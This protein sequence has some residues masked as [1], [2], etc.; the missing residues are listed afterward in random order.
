MA[1]PAAIGMAAAKALPKIA[2]FAKGVGAA[3]D[4]IGE[5]GKQ[6]GETKSVLLSMANAIGGKWIEMQDIAFQTGRSMAM[7]REMAMRYDR[8]LMHST[9]ELARQYGITAKEM[10]DFQKS[11]GEAIGRNVVLTKRQIESM[12]ALSKITDSATA[13]QLVD[14]FDKL[15]VG[16]EGSTA[17]IGL[18]QERAKALGVNASKAAKNL[19]SNIQLASRYSFKNGVADLEKMAIKSA[20]LR[21][22]M[23][24]VMSAADKFMDID[25]AIGTSARLQMLG[26]SF[27]AMFS[28]PMGAMYEAQA[29][30]K[31]FMD[32]LEKLVAGKGRYDSKTGQ[33]TFDPVTMMQM[34]EAA[35]QLGMSV[36]QLTNPAM[37]KVQN[38]KVD[39]ELQKAGTFGNWSEE[40]LEAIRNLSRTNVGEDGKHFVTYIDENG[41]TKKRNIEDLTE[42]ELQIAQDRQLTEEALFSDVQDIKDILDRTLGRARGT[43][44]TKENITGLGEE[45][46]AFV[47]QFQNMFMPLASGMLNGENFRPWDWIKGLSGGFG[48]IGFG[49]RGDEGFGFSNPYAFAEGGI[50]EPIPHAAMGTI[51]P[52]DSYSGD[53][54]PIM[55][56]A[57]EMVLNQREQSGLFSILKSIAT[58]GAMMYGGNK[59]GKMFGMRGLGTQMGIGNLLGG[60]HMGIGG[61]LGTAAGSIAMNKM[62]PMRPM[63]MMPMSPFGMMNRPFTLMNPTV[64][65]NGQT[66][67][68]GSIADGSLVEQ[69]ED[70]ADAAADVTKNT[71]SFSMR[72]RDLSRKDTFL[73]KRARG[74]RKFNVSTGRFFNK[75]KVKARGAFASG[76][77]KFLDSKFMRNLDSYKDTARYELKY[78]RTGEKIYNFKSSFKEFKTNLRDL[79]NDGS[80]A[81]AS[82]AA[83]R[84]QPT[85]IEKVTKVGNIVK[86]EKAVTSAVGKGGKL[87]GTLGKA[88]KFL[89]RAAGPI[90]AALAVGGAISDISSASSQYDSQVDE[91]E[92]SS[93]S[94][95][96]KARAKDRASKQKN[97]GIGGGI[98]SAVG[99]TAGM[100][101]G[102]V[103]GPLGAIGG[104]WL[105]EKAGNFIGK[106][107]GSLFGGGEEKKYLEEEKSK[108]KAIAGNNEDIVRILRSIDHKMPTQSRIS[109][110]FGLKPLEIASSMLSLNPIGIISKVLPKVDS[111]R[112]T[113]KL[114]KTDINLNISG[115]IKLEGGNKSADL[116][117]SKLLD[118][119]EFKRQIADIV[120]RRLNELGNAGGYRKENAQTNTS[121]MY[122]G[123]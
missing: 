39:E 45:W 91:I 123:N 19:A 12:A 63:S 7:S 34:R 2:R 48:T 1:G 57:G 62:M 60:G 33:V 118:T 54:T 40:S 99:A 108:A 41:E 106:G 3:K 16:I 93:M 67:M 37:A 88:G 98:G 92:R 72:L 28:N 4:V 66:I 47:A 59:L 90:G 76:K 95:R 15:G 117:L 20:S 105:G 25:S 89:G 49:S 50:V 114:G 42:Q 102:S 14:E 73:G 75:Y 82:K 13:A 8:Q 121:K 32:R 55:A 83:S 6:A 43:T 103:L 79:F 46:N 96:E 29:D 78:G 36:E 71:R 86:G 100:A 52:G 26:G 97:A 64:V 27:G 109:S 81:Q 18:L 87:L 38:A 110:N 84:I 56:N 85:T 10:A 120:S 51:V 31:A 11:Y 119:P 17:K 9:K 65:M 44:S 24:A 61:M 35:K 122:N 115:T 58:T 107:I 5:L 23:S 21:M 74:L 111:P 116:D 68:N 104:A 77:S 69:L 80:K 112:G 101:L 22:D 70:V 113:E 94:D 30:P 53:K